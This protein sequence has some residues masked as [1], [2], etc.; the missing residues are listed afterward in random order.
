[1]IFDIIISVIIILYIVFTVAAAVYFSNMIM[2]PK[3]QSDDFIIDKTVNLGHFK[4]EDILNLEKEEFNVTSRYGYTLKGC[5]L[6]TAF[7]KQ[8]ENSSKVAV[9]CHGYTSGKFS[10]TGY[11][12][13]LMKLGFTC[14]VYDHRHH[15][16]TGPVAP[17]TMSYLEKYD[18]QSVIDWCYKK[19]GDDIKIITYGESMGSATVLGLYSIDS[20]P[21]LTIADCGFADLHDLCYYLINGY[22]HVPNI[23]PIIPLA[24]LILRIKGGFRL[25]DN[26]PIEGVKKAA[27]PILFCHGS[28]DTFIP[29]AHS[30]EMAKVGPGVRELYL[31]EGAE[32][33]LSKPTRSEEY[34]KR[35]TEFI[36]KYYF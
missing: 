11:A 27:S 17:C 13:I 32:H 5:I 3:C 1:M 14:V 20:R 18:L 25:K 30:K 7:S 24:S 4:K 12:E 34:S 21:V 28:S 26:R 22:F 15:C 10:M 8:R 31:C 19:F 29:C 35:V 2:H 6:D 9:L 23:A 36:Q 16:E 33:A